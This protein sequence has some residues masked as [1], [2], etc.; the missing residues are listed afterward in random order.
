MT[1]SGMAAGNSVT[2]SGIAGAGATGAA[3]AGAA[4]AAGAGAGDHRMV[5]LSRMISSFPAPQAYRR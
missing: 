1:L 3:G 5:L 4:G 2:T